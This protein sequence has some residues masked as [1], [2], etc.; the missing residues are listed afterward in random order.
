MGCCQSS[1]ASR[2]TNPGAGGG[3]Q[4]QTVEATEAPVLIEVS[5]REHAIREVRKVFDEAGVNEH[6][7]VD[8]AE[9]S[10]RLANRNDLDVLMK[11]ACLNALADVRAILSRNSDESMTWDEL[12]AIAEVTAHDLRPA[13]VGCEEAVA[14]EVEQ[15]EEAACEQLEEAACE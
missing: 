5:D 8:K 12:V 2:A 11:K 6:G 14:A 7:H 9:L 10:K 13:V 15:L 1:T 3:G 4:Q